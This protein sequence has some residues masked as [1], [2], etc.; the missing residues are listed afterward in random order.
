MKEKL[1]KDISNVAINATTLG[2]YSIGSFMKIKTLGWDYANGKGYPFK[3]F[4]LNYMNKSEYGGAGVLFTANRWEIAADWSIDING[5]N[6]SVQDYAFLLLNR[7]QLPTNRWSRYDVLV[8][9]LRNTSN[10]LMATL[11]VGDVN[12]N[13]TVKVV[14]LTT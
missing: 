9:H 5:T 4:V 14:K 13:W 8:I 1:Y 7:A 6:Y 3:D 11:E 12:D 2:G 10:L